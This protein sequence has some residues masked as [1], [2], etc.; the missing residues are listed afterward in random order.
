VDGNAFLL[1]QLRAVQNGMIVRNVIDQIRGCLFPPVFVF[2]GKG[3]NDRRRALYP[4]YKTKRTSPGEDLFTSIQ[5]IRDAMSHLPTVQITVPGWEADD[6]IGTLAMQRA[7]AG[8]RV[9]VVTV[10]RD[11]AQLAAHPKIEVTAGYEDITPRQ[12]RLFK[13]TT[14]DSADN[15]RGIPGFGPKSWVLLN[16]PVMEVQLINRKWDTS[17]TAEEMG[18]RPSHFTWCQENFDEL[19]VMWD[20]VGLFGVPAQEI[21]SRLLVG[22]QDL[23]KVEALLKEYML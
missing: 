10:D 22:L 15:I 4:A 11:L 16:K 5:L 1:N 7:S 13:A 21:N 20:I 12:I 3:G 9:R 17:R 6:V 14:G 18:L 2:D 8:E 23:S 19:L